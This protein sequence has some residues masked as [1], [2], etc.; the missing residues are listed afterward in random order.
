MVRSLAAVG[1]F[2][3]L[4]S[5]PRL[6][7]AQDLPESCSDDLSPM[8]IHECLEPLLEESDNELTRLE[9]AAIREIGSNPEDAKA[10]GINQAAV[11]RHFRAG[12]RSWATYVENE[13][14]ALRLSIGTGTDADPASELC[15]LQHNR[16]R[17][18]W[19]KKR[20]VRVAP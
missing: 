6:S 15:L 2:L 1:L 3:A 9:K 13:C 4:S 7:A 20:W 17:I 10:Y 12:E 14:E 5:I 11:L 18:A 19:L 16:E 8:A